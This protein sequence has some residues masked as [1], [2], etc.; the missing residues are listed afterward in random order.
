M[1]LEV[2]E[3][4]RSIEEHPKRM[5]YK[6]F[7]CATV[8]LVLGH[9]VFGEYS[10]L[11][12]IFLAAMPLVVI[13]NKA[14]YIEEKKETLIH[15]ERALLKEH[16]KVLWFFMFIFLGLVTAYFFWFTVL[17]EPILN[18]LFSSQTETITSMTG[19][20][21]RTGYV[22]NNL[23]TLKSILSNNFM[24]LGFCILFSFLYGSGAIFILTWNA[25]ILGV[26]VGDALRSTISKFGAVSH[27]M[28]L[29]YYFQAFSV[30]FSYMIHGV[31][32]IIA[33]FIGALAGGIISFAVVNHDYK[34]K[35]FRHIVVDSIDL[36]IL[37]AIVLLIAGVVE[38]Y[39]TPT[40]F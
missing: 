6:G 16:V 18:T 24:V 25:S 8:G 13:V 14:L 27:H 26:V 3:D 2:I 23:A 35:Q 29:Q 30:S 7:I 12:S 36:I 28:F 5:F 4:L 20:T 17:P 10:S 11:A 9:I 32:E 21:I 15:T 31:F 19:R 38:V 34:S 22:T 37:S 33:Y 1:V 40:L 39:V